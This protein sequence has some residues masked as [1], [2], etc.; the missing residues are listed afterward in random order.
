M[1]F[2]AAIV[3]L[4]LPTSRS[5]G[6]RNRIGVRLVTVSIRA[7]V[8]LLPVPFRVAVCLILVLG[9]VLRFEQATPGNAIYSAGMATSIC[10]LESTSELAAQIELNGPNWRRC[11]ASRR[12]RLRKTWAQFLCVRRSGPEL[13]M[14]MHESSPGDGN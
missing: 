11:L 1:L 13:I 14:I 9:S 8:N 4:R 5:I 6:K 10:E 2:F 3:L 12:L 7:K